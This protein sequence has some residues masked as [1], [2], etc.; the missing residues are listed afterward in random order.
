MK[1][2]GSVEFAMPRAR[3]VLG[4]QRREL[5]VDGH[6]Y[7]S[8]IAMALFL[9]GIFAGQYAEQHSRPKPECRAS[10][11]DGR[12]L[13]TER[14]GVD[15]SPVSCLYTPPSPPNTKRKWL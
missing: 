9:C 12:R 10:L 13:L 11:A 6:V 3:V 5:S 2:G 1:G 7:W 14:L 8:C 15:G 4:D